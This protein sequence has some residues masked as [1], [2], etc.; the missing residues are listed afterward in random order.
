MMH[1]AEA[2]IFDAQ[3]LRAPGQM[4]RWL[5]YAL[6]GAV[7]AL[8]LLAPLLFPADPLRQSLRHALAG[9]DAAAPL[10]YDHLGRSLLARLAAGLRLSLAIALSAVTTAAVLGVALGVLA[11]W[12]GGWMD[13]AAT[14]LADSFLALPGLL[15]VLI[16]TAVVPQTAVAFWIGLSLVLW[17]EYFRLSRALVTRLLAAPAVQASRLLGFGPI[18]IFRRHLWPALAPMLL[19]LAAFGTA[20]S[21]MMIAALGFVSVGM[22]PPAPE[23][24]LMMV[25]LLPYY[26]E[27]P[28]ALMQ[29]VAAMFLTVL[30][31]NLIAGGRRP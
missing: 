14:L 2:F 1:P 25:E 16:V 3:P 28:L 19:T 30:S 23:L 21:I 11:A 31:L 20:T 15:M 18:Y 26:R 5:G 13:R 4:R 9:P 10:G 7:I 8:A 12:R 22:R 29:P 27:A 24:G 6:L 17:I